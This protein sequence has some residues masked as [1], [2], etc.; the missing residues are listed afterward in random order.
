LNEPVFEEQ[1]QHEQYRY[2]YNDLPRIFIV[3]AVSFHIPPINNNQH[4]CEY[5]DKNDGEVN[6]P[7]GN[8]FHPA[9]LRF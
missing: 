6:M 8:N 1:E 4:Q 5:N 9:K 2:Q 3:L 7:S